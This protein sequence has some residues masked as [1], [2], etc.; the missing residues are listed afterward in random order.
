MRISLVTQK[1]PFYLP[2]ALDALCAARQKDIVALIILPSFNEG[3][4]A[5]AA[6]LF[7]F[8]G[9]SD[10][11]RLLGWFVWAK[12]ADHLNRMAA[13][14]RPYSA[15]DVARRYGI[16]IYQPSNINT[17]DFVSVLC[18]K[19]HPDLLVSIAA[20]QILKRHIL[21]IPTKG[22]INLHSAAL[23]Q[24]QGMMPN[25][26]SM[27]HREP[28][29]AVTVH[30]MT[31]KLDKGDVIVQRPVP[32]HPTDSLHDLMLRSKQIGVQAV[33]AAIEQIECGTVTRRSIKN[34]RGTYFS[35][36]KR[37]DAK[38]LRQMG[39]RLL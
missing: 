27:L 3:L 16:P 1:E 35:F 26:W 38:R 15:I 24:Y 5:T 10:F 17:S 36:P 37:V 21:E 25:F 19:I 29:A 6:R 34:D 2:P 23:P 33:L 4:R 28:E 18:N 20:S 32:I 11:A 13:L 22:C 9:P 30:Y 7:Q 31:R 12:L 8:Y 39:H 14:T